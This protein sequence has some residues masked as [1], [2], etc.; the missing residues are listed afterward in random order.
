L[1]LGEGVALKTL[2]TF[3]ANSG[4]K[5]AYLEVTQK[6]PAAPAPI[7]QIDFHSLASFAA[8]NGEFTE[9]RRR[10]GD[11]GE[12]TAADSDSRQGLNSSSWSPCGPFVL[13]TGRRELEFQPA[14][15]ME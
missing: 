8:L 15:R 4:R 7:V 11:L 14:P 9:G 5:I 6:N 13:S 10:T 12:K 1:I 3:V 2:L